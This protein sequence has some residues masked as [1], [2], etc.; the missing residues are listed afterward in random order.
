MANN[1]AQLLITAVDQTRGAFDSIKRNLGDLG[2]AAR[3]IN[4]L[5]GTLGLAVSAAGLG[6]MVKASLDS[7]DSLSK[8]SQRVGI[9]VE[10]LSTLIPVADLA[11]VSGEKFEG[12]LRKLATRMLEAATGTE[13]AA[14]AFDAVGVAFQNQDGTLRST[15][16][17]LLDLTDRFKAMPDGAEKTAIAVELFGKSGADLIPFLNQGRDG[18]EA[19]TAELQALGV[20]IGGDTAAQAEV[21]NDSLAKVRLAISSV[22]NRVIE[23]FLPAMNEMANGM[24]ESAKQGGSLRAILD[25]VVLVLKTLAL[26]AAT[27]GKAFVALGEAIGAGMAAAV[28]ALSGNVSGA[29]AIITELKGSLVQRLDEL[30]SFRD[31]LFDPKPIEVRAPAIVADPTLI[32]RLRTPGRAS[33][34]NGAARLALAKA[35]AD[36]ELKLLKD[37]LDRQSRDLDETLDGRLISLADYY[38]AKSALETREIDAEIV[39]TRALLA[40][41]QR[42]AT[43]GSDEGARLKAKAE[44]AKIE[45]DLIVLN[46]KRA[47][48]EVANARK[49]ADAERELADALTQARE[50]LAQITGQSSAADRRA[51]IERGYRDLKARL[52]AESDADGV[53]LIDRLIDVKAAQAN[54]AALE[55]EWRLVTERLR[56]A[57]E[58]IQ[59]Q[60]Q[61][62]LLT[63]AQARQQIVALQQQSATEMERLLPTMQQAAQAIG[64]DA[65]VR[66]QAWRNELERTKLVVDEMA[67]LWNRIGE[68]FG[69]A[70]N[71][72]ITG[73]QTWRSALATIFQQVADDAFLQQIVIQPFQQWIA[74]QARMLALKLGFVQQEQAVDAAASATT[75]AQKS[76][77]TTAVVSMDAAKAGAGA[78]ASQASIPYVGPALA[79]AAM[80]AMVAA[81]MG[82][83]GNTKKFASGGLVTGPGTSTSDSIPARLS[84]GEFVMNAAAVKRVGVDFLHSIN[85]LS[86]GPRITGHG[87]AFA[88]GGLVPEAP[89]QQ[90]QGQAVRIVNVIDPAMAADYLNSS[91]GEKTILNILQRNAGAVRQVL[92]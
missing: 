2:N 77:E 84:A 57:Q 9:T 37:A 75:V 28:E 40:E 34:D 4:G 22:G 61:A 88:A 66:V 21:F 38:A 91:S 10:S 53:S 65:V 80:V 92:R 60:Q 26:G 68:S 63:E 1:R 73:A 79:V 49:A 56:N 46:N 55:T 44:V 17:V 45:A 43:S 50:E 47:D 19:L 69:G 18:V 90:A 5:L 23:A 51:A 15:D 52:L 11:G 71:G 27:V 3:S 59:T 41:Q 81:V 7:A 54:L 64:P 86:S 87:L 14:R 16:Q 62:G 31:S 36:A 74:M 24:V 83:L 82:L 72:M 85:G 33:G 32:D 39:R 76:A 13:D 35:L 78:A 20:Q 48:V 6:A 12:G 70:L 30:A 42:I 25:G 29:K 67:P 8:L 58:A 89:P